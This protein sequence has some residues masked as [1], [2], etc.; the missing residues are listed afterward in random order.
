MGFATVPTTKLQRFETF[1]AEANE[2]IEAPEFPKEHR[3]AARALLEKCIREY[4]EEHQRDPFF[5]D[6]ADRLGR[7]LARLAVPPPPATPDGEI[8]KHERTLR[9]LHYTGMSS[10]DCGR[11]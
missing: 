10:T 4:V 11:G 8:T 1:T 2:R 7:H 3:S 6:L 5:D 9:E